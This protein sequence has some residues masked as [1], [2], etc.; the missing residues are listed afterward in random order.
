MS[1]RVIVYQNE[2]NL[3]PS[4]VYPAGS[5]IEELIVN[6]PNGIIFN[7]TDLPVY[8]KYFNAWRL[9]NNN[10]IVDLEAC[11]E[12]EIDNLNAKYK[13]MAVERQLNTSIGITNDI[14][15]VDFIASL[16][17]KKNLINAT[18]SVEELSNLVL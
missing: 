5:S 15:D 16:N 8:S 18:T 10:I 1:N 12:V 14:S 17:N 13:Q 11:K 3:N 7:K 9:V 2:D 4:I 6:Y